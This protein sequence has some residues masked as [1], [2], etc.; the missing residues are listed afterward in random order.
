MRVVT[1][2]A[3][4]LPVLGLA[5]AIV[6]LWQ[7]PFHWTYMVL[8]GAM[9]LLT[10]LGIGVGYHRL[11]THKSY[12][13]GAVMRF[14]WAVLGSMAV[15][16]PVLT[17][18]AVHRKHH[19]HADLPG[20]PHSPHAGR[21]S[22]SDNHDGNT[23]HDDH[24]PSGIVALLKGIWHAHMGWLFDG[25]SAELERYVPDLQQDR[26]VSFVS[27]TFA[28]WAALGLVIPAVL[29]GVITMT[30][31]GVL[32]GFLW[33]G[34]VRVL[35]VHHV[36]WSINSVCHLWGTRPFQT[37]DE[38]RDNPIFGVLAMGEG[39]H[40]AHHAFPTSARHGLAWWKID[41]NYWVIRAMG[42]MHLARNIRLPSP[43]R[44]LEKRR[45]RRA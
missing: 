1:L 45:V 4:L 9:Y 41:V 20:D 43:E 6:M 26:V 12:E 5:A 32:L 31:W 44:M 37:R 2:V 15:E 3:V 8:L 11:F 19:Q 25:S 42:W 24:H 28:L 35:L 38:S 18:V 34:L 33:G 27:R 40:N 17:W 7:S 16:G 10:A 39:W 23:D 14:I 22:V 29:G 36:T 21:T 13:T 30:W